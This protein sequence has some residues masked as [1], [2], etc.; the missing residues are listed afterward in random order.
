[1]NIQKPKLLVLLNRLVIGGQALD[2][3]P[4]LLHL[5]NEFDILVLYG[6]K[7]KDEEEAGFLFSKI[8]HISK[9]KLTH[10]KR[11]VNPLRDVVA[12]FSILQAINKFKPDIVHT[13][14]LKS[15]LL[16][17][18]A[19]YL[20]H[21]KCIIHTYH[22]HH[23]H[24]YFGSF[25][26][27]AIVLMERLLARIST[28]IIAISPQQKQEFVT[29][30]K[31][32][33]PKKIQVIPLGIDE[34]LFPPVDAAARQFFRDKYCIGNDTVAIGIVG[35]IVP[36]KNFSMFIQVAV[37]IVAQKNKNKRVK[38]FVVGDGND[39]VRVQKE[40]EELNLS[41]CNA[42]NLNNH[43][44][45]IF[46]SWVQDISGTLQGLDVV[47]LTSYNEGTPLSLIEAQ[48]CG[49]PVVATNV[50]GVK[51]TFLDGESGFL[52][53]PGNVDVFAEKLLLLVNDNNLGK[54]MGNTAVDFAV[55]N[56][57]KAKEIDSFKYLYKSCTK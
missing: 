20:T 23:F 24:S 2:T 15:G 19:A 39:R 33:S 49:K 43:A 53:P 21:T 3:I 30:Y 8:K 48:F 5:Q 28:K 40:I 14:G 36:I 51:D 17:R 35:R 41:W 11:S 50:G 42:D 4:L 10:F 46:T 52:V 7:E 16:G 22:G 38:F 18:T 32:A 12:F 1:M 34:R 25:V 56:F 45:I 57:S 9:K 54:K 31:I 26:S 29:Q 37:A 47:V 44:D 6:C 55:K 27:T 13:H